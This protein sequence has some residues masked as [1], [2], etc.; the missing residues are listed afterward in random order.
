MFVQQQ[1]APPASGERVGSSS[2]DDLSAHCLV[3]AAAVRCAHV[4]LQCN[5]PQADGPRVVTYRSLH[6]CR[7]QRK[8]G[9]LQ[10]LVVFTDVDVVAHT[11]PI[12]RLVVLLAK[13]FSVG[14]P[15]AQ[16]IAPLNHCM[17]AVL[18]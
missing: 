4:H 9:R 1:A 13:T 6:D 2:E 8:H 18:V 7:L 11:G 17:F 16:R 10:R 14:A 15:Y 12:P 5:D 3:C